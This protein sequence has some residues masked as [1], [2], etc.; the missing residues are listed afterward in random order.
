MKKTYKSSEDLIKLYSKI[1]K[2]STSIYEDDSSKIRAAGI[3]DIE[4]GFYNDSKYDKV[5]FPLAVVE[6]DPKAKVED[7]D[8]F[9]NELANYQV[10]RILQEFSPINFRDIK[11]INWIARQIF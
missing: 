3:C 10:Y 6:Y 11:V 1:V 9:W 8:E 4:V 5:E 7:T 2:E